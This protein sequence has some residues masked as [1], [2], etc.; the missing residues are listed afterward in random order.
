MSIKVEMT[1]FRFSCHVGNARDPVAEL[2]WESIDNNSFCLD[3]KTLL[4]RENLFSR[5][6]S[7]SDF[8]KPLP[9]PPEEDTSLPYDITN[10]RNYSLAI[11]GEAFRWIV[12]YASPETLQ[13]VR[14]RTSSVKCCKRSNYSNRFSSEAKCLPECL[15]TR[16]TN[17]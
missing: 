3:N 4:V 1:H 2:Q 15:R 11:S 16:N 17:W 9:A 7:Q 12:D 6:I 10:L 13:R 8:A 5:S 14:W